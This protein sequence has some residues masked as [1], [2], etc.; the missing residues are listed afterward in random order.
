[1]AVATR[2]AERVHLDVEGMTC[3]SCAARNERKLEP[4]AT[5]R[6]AQ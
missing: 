6:I 3:A 4:E 1:M 5:T 2:P